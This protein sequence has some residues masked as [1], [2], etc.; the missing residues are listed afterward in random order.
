MDGWKIE[1]RILSG[2]GSPE[3]P[4]ALGVGNPKGLDSDPGAGPAVL[5]R[6]VGSGVDLSV[7]LGIGNDNGTEAG[8]ENVGRCGSNVSLV[9]APGKEKGGENGLGIPEGTMG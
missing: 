2:L 3:P 1:D 6:S 5:G 9:G 4:P 8:I 7:V